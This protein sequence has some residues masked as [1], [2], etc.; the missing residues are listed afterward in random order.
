MYEKESG[1]LLFSYFLMSV[2]RMKSKSNYFALFPINYARWLHYWYY[3][4]ENSLKRDEKVNKKFFPHFCLLSSWFLS[5]AVQIMI[6]TR[7]SQIRYF[8][9]GTLVMKGQSCM[10]VEHKMNV[11]AKLLKELFSKC[12]RGESKTGREMMRLNIKKKVIESSLNCESCSFNFWK[13]W[14][15][16]DELAKQTSWKFI[17]EICWIYLFARFDSIELLF[18]YHSHSLSD[19]I[20]R[21]FSCSFRL[22][23]I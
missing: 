13:R 8:I 10:K 22:F 19:N 5:A 20:L 18:C 11:T 15:I 1:I 7:A 6:Q 17:D 14:W 21:I 23:F 2:P 16:R 3:Q 9:Y 4:M 12:E